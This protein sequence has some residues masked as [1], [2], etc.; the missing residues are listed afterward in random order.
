MNQWKILSIS[1]CL[2]VGFVVTVGAEPLT[3]A[4]VTGG[5][6]L[7]GSGISAVG[8]GI[9]A[10][11]QAE[12]EEKR[13]LEEQERFEQQLSLQRRTTERSQGL[14]GIQFLAGQRAQA[15]Q[16]FGRQRFRDSLLSAVRGS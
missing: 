8:A 12:E 4:L 3:A 6:A 2:F 10:K 14:Q 1:L 15:S 13:R 16:Q 9:S 11:R 7:L 5:A